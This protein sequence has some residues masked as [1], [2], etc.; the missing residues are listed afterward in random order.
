METIMLNDG[1][2]INGHVQHVGG[3]LWF[4]LDG[5]TFSEAYEAM[6]EPEATQKITASVY[7]TETVY[8][9]FSELFC[10][11]LEDSGQ[12]TGGLKHA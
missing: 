7:G 2:E 12:V 9:G 10:L 3:V 8:E 4:Y 1:R 11:R 5:L 6:S